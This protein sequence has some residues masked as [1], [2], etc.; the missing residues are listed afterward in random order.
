ML[1]LTLKTKFVPATNLTGDKASADW[2]FLLPSVKQ[3]TVVCIGIP[4]APVLSVLAGSST[5]VWV[6]STKRVQIETAMAKAQALP[7]NVH[8]LYVNE[9]S[10]LPL[11]D[12]EASLV[13][14]AEPLT[15]TKTVC[16]DRFLAELERVLSPVGSIYL[17]SKGLSAPFV[18]RTIKRAFHNQ[19]IGLYQGYWLTPQSGDLQTAVPLEQLGIS[20]FFFANVL[21]GHSFRKRMLSQLGKT[22]SGKQKIFS[23]LPYRRTMILQRSHA[24]KHVAGPPDYLTSLAEQAAIDLTDYNFGFSARGKYNANKVIFYLFSR[25]SEKLEI[26]VQMTRSRE[27]NFRLQNAYSVLKQV[28]NKQLVDT[29][30]IP[31]PLFLGAHN[32]LA[33]LGQKA[34]QG[35]PFRLRTLATPECP[36]ARNAVDWIVRLGKHSAD[37]YAASPD[38]VAQAL[39]KLLEQLVGIYRLSEKHKL[40][41]SRQIASI[42]Q[43]SENFPLVFQHGDPGTWNMLVS[44]QGQVIVIDWEAGEPQG[45]P[46][47]DL[48]YFFRSF[49]AWIARTQ[50]QRNSLTAFFQN[51][52]TPSPLASLLIEATRCYIHNTGLEENLV[53]PLFYMCWVH[54]ALKEATRLEVD[55]LEKGHFVN[56]LRMCIENNDAP[57]LKA[58]FR[59]GKHSQTPAFIHRKKG[60]IPNQNDKNEI[61]TI[62]VVR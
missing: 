28:R 31:E 43:S 29:N 26:V 17:E 6:F 35:E 25:R 14:F 45:I 9:H 53:E 32:G 13:F 33:I 34:V 22:L 46:L 51:F 23:L 10:S 38:Q 7:I 60:I 62:S 5:R 36:I 49:A 52:F 47:W 55:S 48:F 57:G 50:G 11:A 12:K 21:F 58:L 27:F 16:C 56:L 3:S 41:L 20:R 42:S 54:R 18:S 1:D 37:R 40:F 39:D 8:F 59:A 15:N 24:A 44:D 2:R 19:G 30:S 61:V 4:S